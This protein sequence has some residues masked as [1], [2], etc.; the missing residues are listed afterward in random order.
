ML[1]Y[2]KTPTVL[3]LQKPQRHLG[4]NVCAPLAGADPGFGERGAP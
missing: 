1:V 4:P 3:I 2:S